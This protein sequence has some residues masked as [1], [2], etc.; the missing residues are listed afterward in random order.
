MHPEKFAELVSDVTRVNI[1]FVDLGLERVKHVAE[2]LGLMHFDVPVVTI[3][4]TNGKGT[5]TN[6]LHRLL[7]VQGHRVAMFTSP[8]IHTVNEQMV[9]GDKSPS[10]EDL[11]ST[12]ERVR[13]VLTGEELTYFEFV[14]LT[15]L[16]FFQDNQPDIVLLEVGLGGRLDAT[17]IVDADVSV[18]TTVDFDH[19]HLL[20]DTRDKIGLEKAGIFRTGNPAVCGDP[21]PP[22]S[23]LDHA[24]SLGVP[25]AIQGQDFSYQISGAH[26]A[27]QGNGQLLE[28]LPVPNIPVQNASTA[29]MVLSHIPV[30]I[31]WSQEKIAA[32]MNHFGV[33][34]RMQ[35]FQLGVEILLDVAHNPQSTQYLLEYLQAHPAQGKTVFLF[36]AL[37][38]KDHQT[39]L[40]P[41]YTLK[42]EWHFAGLPGERA[43]PVEVLKNILPEDAV[44]H[45]N[46]LVAC[47]SLIQ[48]LDCE[49][50][51][52]IFG[53][54][55]T[56]AE[57]LPWL[58][59]QSELTSA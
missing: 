58:K 11:L 12:V 5:T 47:Q 53:S 23:V 55:H 1:H 44:E 26:W 28:Q 10:D 57:V 50:R 30:A 48:S 7:T 24:K 17:N 56:I 29:L 22:S 38:E 32:A 27:W 43:A 14:I 6:L 13:T 8:C 4:G 41:L 21:N 19:Q 20:G 46:I 9:V 40:M 2:Q 18:I 3:A 42:A 36:S 15:A 45:E 35:R 34:G 25:I 59:Q 37:K 16:Q 49:D 52:V 39:M 33:T 31:D 54:F 51:L